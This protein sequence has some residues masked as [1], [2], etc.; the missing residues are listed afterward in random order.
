MTL[1]GGE[2]ASSSLSSGVVERRERRRGGEDG[3]GVT[4][5]TMAGGE[6]PYSSSLSTTPKRTVKRPPLLS[7]RTRHRGDA[8]T[9]GTV[10]PLLQLSSSSSLLLGQRS[11]DGVVGGGTYAVADVPRCFYLLCRGRDPHTA[12][13]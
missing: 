12:V 10:D 6:V 13:G 3:S 7:F 8:E 9:G 1:A 2:F 5:M 4:T 11:R